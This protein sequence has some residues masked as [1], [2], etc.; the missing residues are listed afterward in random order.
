V[1]PNA[2]VQRGVLPY[3][4]LHSMHDL[5]QLPVRRRHWLRPPHNLG[6]KYRATTLCHGDRELRAIQQRATR[7]FPARRANE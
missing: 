1:V 2:A 3:V 5:L 6:R 7:C 4:P